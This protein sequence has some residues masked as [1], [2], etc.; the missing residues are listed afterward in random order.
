LLFRSY[1]RE[2]SNLH[3]ER[4]VPNRDVAFQV[5]IVTDDQLRD[6]IVSRDKET[7]SSYSTQHEPNDWPSLWDIPK[8]FVT[9]FA[10]PLAIGVTLY[11]FTRNESIALE[12]SFVLQLL[13]L[14]L[15]AW[16]FRCRKY[17][18]TYADGLAL[19]KPTLRAVAVAVLSGL[20]LPALM[21]FT[22]YYMFSEPD[23]LE[24]PFK[25]LLTSSPGRWALVAGALLTVPFEEVFFRGF[26]FAHLDERLGPFIAVIIS[27]LLFALIHVLQ[28]GPN[29]VYVIQILMV[30]G[31][32]ALQR[33]YAHSVIPGMITHGIYNAFSTSIMILGSS[34]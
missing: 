8:A 31:V 21:L 27:S 7:Y 1:F 17:Q 12:L 11:F 6:P 24:S 33:H 9:A 19:R 28:F 13:S 25:E 32:F 22:A 5:L 16:Y 34:D 30:G 20:V 23:L 18:L 4:S 15:A 14:W 26:I 29:V 3:G 2:A 10:L